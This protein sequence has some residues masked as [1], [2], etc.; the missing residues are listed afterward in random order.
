VTVVTRVDHIELIVHHFEEYV[1]LFRALGFREIARTR[2]H[3]DSVEFQL[4]GEHQPIFEIHKAGGE[5]SIGINHLAFQVADVQG[6]RHALAAQGVRV[7]DEPVFVRA[8]GRTVLNFRDPD[9]WRLQLVDARR[10][11]PDLGTAH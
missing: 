8:T 3:G 6:A 9:G 10:E 2:H 11:R 1:A 7:P 5:E 4:P